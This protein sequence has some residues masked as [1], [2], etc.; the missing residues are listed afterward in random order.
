ME[1]WHLNYDGFRIFWSFKNNL[2]PCK[3]AF[4]SRWMRKPVLLIPYFPQER[5]IAEKRY[6]D[7]MKCIIR[8]YI[9]AEQKKAEEFRWIIVCDVTVFAR[10]IRDVIMF[11]GWQR[12][13]FLHSLFSLLGNCKC[14]IRSTCDN[15]SFDRIMRLSLWITLNKK[16]DFK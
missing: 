3:R 15:I 9:T 10:P 12:K 5:E 13:T 6:R 14:K 4:K 2:R 7:V 8:R 1:N 16:N 11:F